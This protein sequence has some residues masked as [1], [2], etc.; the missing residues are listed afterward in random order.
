MFL[1]RLDNV[2]PK[3]SNRILLNLANERSNIDTDCFGCEV[4]LCDG[5]HAIG[6]LKVR[7]VGRTMT[8]GVIRRQRHD[9]FGNLFFSGMAVVILVSVFTGF[10]HSDYVS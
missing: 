2:A 9:R 1:P 10:A 3:S 7:L 5:L 8:S 6:V 4:N